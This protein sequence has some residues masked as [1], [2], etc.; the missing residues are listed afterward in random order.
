MTTA[1]DGKRYRTKVFHLDVVISVGYR[2]QFR[3]GVEFKRWAPACC[4][5]I[6]SP[7]ML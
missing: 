1:S 2:V 7:V 3:R 6:S 4:A 5:N